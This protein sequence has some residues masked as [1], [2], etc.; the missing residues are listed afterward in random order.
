MI[1]KNLNYSDE[2]F[3]KLVSGVDQLAKAVVSTLGSSGRT[4][5]IEDQFGQPHVTKDGV[6]VA[7]SII[8]SDPVENLGASILKQASQKTADE[9]GDGTTTSCVL[10]QS[11][12]HEIAGNKEAIVNVHEVKKG[13]DFAATE[14]IKILSENKKD[15]GLDDL[16][17]VA[18]ISANG[19]EYIGGM[20]ADAY[21]KVGKSGIVTMD[22]S[23]TGEDYIEVTKGTR[24]KRGYGT[25][26]SVNNIRQSTV[27]Y[28]NPLIVISDFK[29][30]MH[31]RLHFAFEQSI[32]QK[33]PLLIIS[34][35]DDRVK[36]FIT[37]NINKKNLTANFIT[38]E[39][40][41]ISRFELL[42]DLAMITGGKVM[43]EMA[44]DSIQNID[45][46][47]LGTCK[48][49]ISDISET[50]LI[51]EEGENTERDETIKWLEDKVKTCAKHER[52]HYEDRLAKLS[53]GVATIR[54][55]ANSEVELKEKR[56]R[57]DD[58]IHATKAALEEGIVAG[59]GAA[60]LYTYKKLKNPSKEYSSDFN[61][62]FWI[63]KR[64]LL[65]PIETLLANA[66][67]IDS[68]MKNKLIRNANKDYG[69]NLLN[70]KTGNMFDM[71]IVDPFKVTKNAI[72]NSKSVAATLLTTSC[73]ISNKRISNESSR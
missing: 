15:V 13:M 65:S 48:T 11:M 61:L 22:D 34:D 40:V 64:S 39:G 46:S 28:S 67:M 63:V 26:F 23:L 16:V 50:I 62:G 30:D 19:D 53:G 58:S 72:L 5:I 35:L 37:Q 1:E 18:T 54:L 55:S 73:V 17:R 60:M 20:I 68:P 2:A 4:V 14:A 43:S 52:Y 47:Y 49:M 6:T 36:L 56:D 69:V 31:E 8:L 59:G 38:P 41:G 44:G 70:Y 25:P 10:A 32:K 3:E 66:G 33:R 42:N 51:F 57:V 9:A 71:G 21:S 24:I 12:V 45:A 27:E 7:N 29:I